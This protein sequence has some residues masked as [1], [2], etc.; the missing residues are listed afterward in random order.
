MNVGIVTPRYPPNNS[1]GGEVSARLLVRMLSNCSEVDE[2]TVYTFDGSGPTKQ[3]GVQVRRY[4]S[5]SIFSFEVINTYG[6]LKLRSALPEDDIDI[7]HSYNM[8]L[9]PIVGHLSDE[10]SIPSVATLNS[11]AY[12]PYR[13][14]DIPVINLLELY[15]TVSWATSGS[16]LRN[17]IQ[18]VDVYIALSKTVADIY[19]DMMLNGQDI[20]VIPNMCEPDLTDSADEG[21][22]ANPETKDSQSKI[23]YVGSLRK[24]KGV[25]YLVR[26]A[27]HLPD[28]YQ[29]TIA[30]S[31]DNEENLRVLT[32]DIG[33]DEQITFLGR[34]PHDR[35]Q[36]LY[37]KADLFV[38]PGIWPEPF[39]RTIL[40]AMQ[41][42]LPVVA[43]DIGGPAEIIPQEQSLC[44]PKD[45]IALAQTIQDVKSNSVELGNENQEYVWETYSPEVVLPKILNTY[46]SVTS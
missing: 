44:E 33:V 36:E 34:V 27:T 17:R 2:V 5:P 1:G 37:T 43:T 9:H 22:N 10:L 3:D 4:N 40:E 45:P 25:E 30:G 21:T 19:H 12:I 42:G 16:V 6:Y 29:I 11:Y 14:I 13:K 35:V 31:G 26:A 15:K 41:F 24:T 23:L 18:K 20:E 28:S 39:G 8:Q 7:I 46:R 38:H 32:R